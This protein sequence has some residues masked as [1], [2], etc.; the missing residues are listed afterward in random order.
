VTALE[1]SVRVRCGVQC[2]CNE[3]CAKLS[4]C[5]MGK[6]K[7]TSTIYNESC[8]YNWKEEAKVSKQ[9]QNATIVKIR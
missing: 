6:S 2:S 9:A 5:E 8:V 4:E 1:R 3:S 7:L